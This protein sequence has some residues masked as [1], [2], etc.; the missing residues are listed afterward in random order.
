MLGQM[1]IRSAAFYSKS[2]V[3]AGKKL[4]LT[5]MVLSSTPNIC[6]HLQQHDFK[7]GPNSSHTVLMIGDFGQ[8][9]D[10]LMIGRYHI[11]GSNPQQFTQTAQR[12]LQEGKT[13][14]SIAQLLHFDKQCRPQ[15]GEG[16]YADSGKIYI[17][18][19]NFSQASAALGSFQLQ[20]LDHPRQTV[21]GAFAAV[22]CPALEGL[23]TRSGRLWIPEWMSDILPSGNGEQ[24]VRQLLTCE[25]SESNPN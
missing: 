9:S 3:A 18:E 21:R 12:M 8:K 11:L 14:L 1:P 20:V 13:S 15:H 25:K 5:S 4:T 6:K 10:E 16:I 23:L 22:P 2:F 24:D 19:I 7:V 17:K